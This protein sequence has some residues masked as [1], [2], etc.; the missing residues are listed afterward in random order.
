[1]KQKKQPQPGT[2]L[3]EQSKGTKKLRYSKSEEVKMLENM[4]DADA[5]RRFPNVPYLAPRTYS[6]K[7]TN[8]LSKCVIDFLRLKG[9]HCE[10][11]GNEGRLIDN[12]KAVTDVLGNVRTIG[13]I[14]RVYGSSMRGTSDLKA[15]FP[16]GKFVAIEIKCT[17]TNDRIRPEQLV[18]K[19]AIEAAS[20]IYIVASSFAGFYDWY[21]QTFGEVQ[22]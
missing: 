6:D 18:Y 2:T 11:T 22:L 15:V 3:F 10:R 8:E 1:M 20:G 13:R 19:E 14:Q 5:K 9:H 17:A 16:G 21:N 4:A 7:T 12:R